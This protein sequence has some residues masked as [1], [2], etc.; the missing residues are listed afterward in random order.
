MD[1]T[2]LIQ[3]I[4]ANN[5]DIDKF[6][7]VAITDERAR[8]EIIHQM[9][10][11]PNISV[12]YHCYYVVSKA[13]QVKPEL[14]YRYWSDMAALLDHKNSYHRD[15]ALT[16]LAN[17][18]Q[19]DWENKF[20]EISQDY[21]NHVNDPKFMTGQCCII[22]TLKIFRHKPEM[23]NQIIALLLDMDNQCNYSEKQTALLKSD[24]LD[25]FDAVYEEAGEKARINEFINASM[26]SISPKTKRKAKELARKYAL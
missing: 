21:F 12:Y 18:T 17:L 11:N 25:I 26:T 7:Q 9:A 24:I 1:T 3:A 5:V 16:I 8:E 2:E 22:N 23:R 20:A 14:F 19:V 4:S 10:I 15:I 6:V 13:S